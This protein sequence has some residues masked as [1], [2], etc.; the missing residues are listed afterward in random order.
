MGI[1]TAQ[2]ENILETP[3]S[4]PEIDGMS[5]FSLESIGF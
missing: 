3:Q 1:I 5:T 2:L 4:I